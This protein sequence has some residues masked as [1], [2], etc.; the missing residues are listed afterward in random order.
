[1]RV[2]RFD[3]AP[4]YSPPLHSGVDC[5]RLQGHEA[6]PTERFWIGLSLYHPGGAAEESATAEE[7]IYTVLDG[8][9]TIL[10]DGREETL[11][12]FDSVHLPKGAVRKV[13][14]RSG[15][16]ATLLVAIATPLAST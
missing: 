8:A 7:T 2:V 3:Q 11:G 1:M 16:P 14:N 6:G 12:R 15:A 5:R 10:A 13:E 4:R 9:L